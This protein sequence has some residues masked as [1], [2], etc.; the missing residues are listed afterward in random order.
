MGGKQLVQFQKVIQ[1][2]QLVRFIVCS[3]ADCKANVWV[4]NKCAESGW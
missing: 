2:K 3:F 4:R 1:S